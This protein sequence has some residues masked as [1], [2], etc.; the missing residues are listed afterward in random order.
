MRANAGVPSCMRVPPEDGEMSSGSCS[1]VA[2]WIA[3]IMRRAV[4][5][6][7]EPPRKVNSLR[8]KATLVPEIIP[9]PVM[10]AS[11]TPDLVL[12]RSIAAR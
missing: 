8:T 12:A 9:S 3:V 6:P 7:M 1:A 10:T 2:R 4:A 11:S 5:A